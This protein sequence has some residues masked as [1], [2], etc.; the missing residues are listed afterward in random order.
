MGITLL[1]KSGTAY[2]HP[3]RT[4]GLQIG[5]NLPLDESSSWLA[6]APLQAASLSKDTP[7]T[8]VR[9]STRLAVRRNRHGERA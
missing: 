5:A 8:P 7:S 2:V 6:R 1:G 4:P 3:L 9:S